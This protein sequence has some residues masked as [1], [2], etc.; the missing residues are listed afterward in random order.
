MAKQGQHASVKILAKD[1]VRTRKYITKFIEM[2]SHLQGAA[3]QIEMVKSHEALASSM[4][5][6]T[7]SMVAMNKQVNLPQITKIMQDFAREQEK[8]EMTGEMLG[9]AMD[10][11]MMD[12]NDEEEQEKVVGAILDELGLKFGE[13][14]PDVPTGE[15]TREAE[16]TEETDPAVNELEA[17]LKNLTRQG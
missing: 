12:D 11:A 6:V 13:D 14:I 15:Q 10:D 7:K 2:R 5:A 16:K 4:K 9:D 8:S 17:R 3:L 1:L